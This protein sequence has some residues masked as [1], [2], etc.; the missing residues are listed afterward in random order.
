MPTRRSS[1]CRPSS[2]ASAG[3]V[4]EFVLP[5]SRRNPSHTTDLTGTLPAY[6]GN[7]TTPMYAA[8]EVPVTLGALP[9]QREPLD[10][11]VRR[12]TTDGVVLDR[13]TPGA[14]PQ[15]DTLVA[16]V[17][18][19]R[20]DA[21]VHHL[22]RQLG[23]AT[24]TATHPAVESAILVPTRPSGPRSGTRA[25]ASGGPAT[26]APPAATFNTTSRSCATPTRSASA[27]ASSFRA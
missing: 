24:A 18:L 11:N 23:T 26:A 16:I 21:D 15:N 7:P 10:A 27:A 5:V 13:L 19:T 8:H 12:M 22:R 17:A 20:Q 2:P 4:R 9:L 14:A 6:V 1:R 25:A 3:R